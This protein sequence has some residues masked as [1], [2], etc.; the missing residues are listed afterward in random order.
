LSIPL[1][2]HEALR[3]AVDG[4]PRCVDVGRFQQ[5]LFLLMAGM[6]FDG[7]IVN[8]VNSDTLNRLK[9]L[10]YF[11]QGLRLLPAYP[12]HEFHIYRG[13]QSMREKA[14]LAVIA[15]ASSYTYHAA[16]FPGTK[17]DD[18]RLNVFLFTHCG[19]RE[20]ARQA[21]AL[22]LRRPLPASIQ[23]FSGDSVEIEI[24]PPA[25]VQVD[26]DA[27]GMISAAH[28]EIIPR[29]LQIMAGKAS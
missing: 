24:V 12:A 27:A 15:N 20:R 2:L 18:G 11:F 9:A 25:A 29:C 1:S 14:W 17:I 7:A 6:G 28:V 23:Q 22:L 19:R 5:R 3:V 21:V 4:F 16:L 26:G 10:A 13:S 8:S